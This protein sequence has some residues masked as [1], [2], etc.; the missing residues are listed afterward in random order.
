MTKQMQKSVSINHLVAAQIL[1]VKENK[2][3]IHQKYDIPICAEKREKIGSIAKE[4]S[5]RE[6]YENYTAYKER[7]L[8]EL[9]SLVPSYRSVERILSIITAKMYWGHSLRAC[10]TETN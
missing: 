3:D 10:N 1:L 5:Y 8:L 9:P 2:Q 6:L 7:N 4:R